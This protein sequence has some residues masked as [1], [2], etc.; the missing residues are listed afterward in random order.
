MK[1]LYLSHVRDS[2]GWADAAINGMR[3]LV[4]AGCEVVAHFIRHQLEID[5][6][7][8]VAKVDVKNAFNE[9]ASASIL[10]RLHRHLYYIQ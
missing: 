10:D 1:V 2:S 8:V 3:S 4:A 9:I 5:P 7:V 6:S